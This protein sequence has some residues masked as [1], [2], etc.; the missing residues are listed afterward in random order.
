[1]KKSKGKHP[2]LVLGYDRGKAFSRTLSDAGLS[3]TFLNSMEGLLYA[4]THTQARAI[5][6]DREQKLADELEL[7]L[8]VRDMDGEIPIILVGSI[9]E[10]RTDKILL[11]QPATFLIRKPIND[12]SLA[13]ELQ[14][15]TGTKAK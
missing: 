13:R 11:D 10:Q 9:S 1:M 14:A 4:L 15:L 7:A 2:V 5:L 6:V 3:L 12:N 8:N